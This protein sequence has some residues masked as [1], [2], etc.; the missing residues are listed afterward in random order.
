[1]KKTEST[2]GKNDLMGNNMYIRLYHYSQRY[3]S[4]PWLA[5]IGFKNGTPDTLKNILISYGFPLFASIL[6]YFPGSFYSAYPD[7]TLFY[8]ACILITAFGTWIGRFRTGI[9]TVG[10]LVIEILFFFRPISP[11]FVI[12]IDGLVHLIVFIA[13]AGLIS[14]L[15]DISLRSKEVEQLKNKE[16]NYAKTFTQL[17][18]EYA[19]ACA[20]IKAR[21]EFLSIASHEL[22]T[23]LTSMLMKLH[24]MINSI[25]SESLA[26][27]S[28]PALMNVLENAEQQIKLLA[29]M[30]NDLL[31]VSLI[32]TG[33]MNLDSRECDLVEIA[34][35]VTQNFSEKLKE[36]KY[37]IKTKYS[38]AVVGKWDDARIEQAI[39]SLFS[40]AIKYGEGKPIFVSVHNSGNT[41]KFSIQDQGIGIAHKDQKVLF[42]RFKRAVN[43]EEYKK[44]LG[45]GLY[46]TDQIVKAHGGTIK[47]SSS[48]HK[49]STFLIEL[50]LSN[51]KI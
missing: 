35:R 47:I 29:T 16:K 46:V 43:T 45:V 40:N 11:A 22:R 23:P 6:M 39:T 19:K 14:A 13:T 36:K 4:Y 17:H 8:L 26:N 37:K 10:L 12:D 32:T 25:R 9:L 48:P 21:D 3:V 49:G 34:K 15:I 27:F 41:A 5:T 51:S 28:V 42:E 7:K 33:H 31:N 24:G 50:P 38:K 2:R 44:G 30:I 20:E 18:T 1:M